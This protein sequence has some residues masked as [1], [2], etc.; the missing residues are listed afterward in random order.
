MLGDQ[1][2]C[3]ADRGCRI[4]SV[5]VVVL[6]STLIERVTLEFQRVTVL[7]QWKLDTEMRGTT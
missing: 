3:T 5:E 7:Q 1:E 4:V 6:L 2:P